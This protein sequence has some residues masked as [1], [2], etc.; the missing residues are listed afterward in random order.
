MEANFTR[1]T[2]CAPFDYC[3]VTA[4]LVSDRS[5]WDVTVPHTSK[6][7]LVLTAA[8]NEPSLPLIL[9]TIDLR[10]FLRCSRVRKCDNVKVTACIIYR[11]RKSLN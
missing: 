5:I 6:Y 8:N 4:I 1:G 7:V 11:Q 10:I 9:S 3:N 2:K